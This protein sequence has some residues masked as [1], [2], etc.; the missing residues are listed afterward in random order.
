VVVRQ[1]EVESAELVRELTERLEE[2][3][4]EGLGHLLVQDLEAIQ[5]DG[6]PVLLRRAGVEAGLGEQPRLWLDVD[7]PEALLRGELGEAL[8]ELGGQVDPLDALARDGSQGRLIS[9]ERLAGGCRVRL[10]APFFSP[11]AL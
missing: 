11:F 5:V 1:I 8:A 3:V 6:G 2:L 10:G 7:A 4:S 9:G